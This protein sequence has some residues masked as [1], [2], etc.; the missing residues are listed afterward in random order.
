MARRIRVFSDTRI[1]MV[2]ARADEEHARLGREA[3]ADDYLTKPFRPRDLRARVDA[4]LAGRL[5]D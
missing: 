2:T 3:G 4:L 1:V 5:D